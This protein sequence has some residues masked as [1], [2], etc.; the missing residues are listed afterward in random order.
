MDF[1]PVLYVFRMLAPEFKDIDDETV[2][3]WIGLTTLLIGPKRFGKLYIQALALLTAH[4]MKL[5]GLGTVEGE[6]PLED[7]GNISASNL[8]RV[9]SVSEGGV[10]ISLNSGV[11]QTLSSTAEFRLTTYGVQYLRLNKMLMSITSAGEGYVRP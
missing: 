11:G 2:E 7:I 3:Q 6:D 4:R 9:G 1:T 5:A 10:S 8:M